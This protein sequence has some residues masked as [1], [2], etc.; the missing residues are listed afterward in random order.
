VCVTTLEQRVIEL[1]HAHEDTNKAHVSLVEVRRADSHTRPH[2]SNDHES[3][4][5]REKREKE[6]RERREREKREKRE[7]GE[8]RDTIVCPLTW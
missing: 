8:R 1:E 3:R 4:E 6:E 2:E 5:E 7:R